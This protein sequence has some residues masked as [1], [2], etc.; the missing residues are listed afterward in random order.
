M[1]E[2]PEKKRVVTRRELLSMAGAA[3][4][5][6]LAGACTVQPQ[7]I[8][9][10]V[11]VEVEKEV[12][13]IVTVEVE[14]EIEQIAEAT[15][16]AAVSQIKVEGAL[17]VLQ[18]RDFHNSYNDYL[19]AQIS[20]FTNAQGWL[21]DISYIDGF[22]SGSGEVEKIAAAVQSGNPPDLILHTLS[23]VQLRNLYAVDPV[24]DVVE[25]VEA[26]WGKATP[27]MY[28]DY[29]FE[30]QWWAVPY[31]QRSD[32]GWYRRD[33]WEPAGIDV[34]QIK[35]YDQLLEAAAEISDPDNELFG[36]GM[37]VNRCGDGNYL[38]N[39]IKTGWGAAWQDE[40][41][42]FVTANSPEMI[43]AMEFI[44]DVYT[45]PQWE[46][47]LPPGVLAWN[48]VSNNEAYLSGTL[49]YTQNGG[50]VYAKAVIDGNPVAENTG[51]HMP[52]G[53]P[54]IEAFNILTGKPWLVLRGA[55]NGR[56]AK[57]V[58]RYFLIDL[59]R[60][61]AMLAASP[62]FALPC[63][64]D[65]WEKSEYIQTNEVALQ[66]KSS[67]LDPSGIDPDIYPGPP[68]A[69]IVALDDAGIWN[70]MVN[71]VLTQ[72]PVEQAVQEA[73]ERMVAVFQEFGLPGE[74]S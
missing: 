58:I 54:V 20:E 42:Q 64:T 1:T 45:N 28:I 29:F 8:E 72:T 22:T 35:R 7:T 33:I 63:Y 55:K 3:G 13:K 40:T 9:K 23:A 6:L 5:G 69:A 14:K 10:L 68:S 49:A 51:Y 47:A 32:G 67:T 52:A 15:P 73:H 37:T 36:W 39:R 66:Q 44:K 60:I 4:V 19:R 27:K 17:W 48:D 56:A 26:M 12:E 65:L 50:T 30:D 21:L 71:A 25:E 11:T 62:A 53:G 61:D 57:E 70:D 46:R 2:E 34:S 38:I 18:G 59:A 24:G 43:A 74:P 41:G 31:H 16:S